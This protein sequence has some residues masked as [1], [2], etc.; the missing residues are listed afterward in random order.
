M[1]QKSTTIKIKKGQQYMWEDEPD[2]NCDIFDYPCETEYGKCRWK[3]G[4]PLPYLFTDLTTGYHEI[5]RKTPYQAEFMINHEKTEESAKRREKENKNGD[6]TKLEK[7][8]KQKKELEKK[9]EQQNEKIEK[10]SEKSEKKKMSQAKHYKKKTGK[11]K[12]KAK[13]MKTMKT[14]KTM[15]AMKR[16]GN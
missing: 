15:K 11:G 4:M 12:A 16:K 13:P 5:K 3:K 8:E 10:A 9:I 14:M 1:A 7:L 6:W 2:E